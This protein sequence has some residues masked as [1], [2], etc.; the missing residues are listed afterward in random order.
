MPSCRGDP[1]FAVHQNGL[2]EELFGAWKWRRMPVR[3]QRAPGTNVLCLS[4]VA[5][6]L[7]AKNGNSGLELAYIPFHELVLEIAR[8][9]V[10]K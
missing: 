2:T 6:L 4:A 7:S 5:E 8:C 3:Y 10:E 9:G 1:H